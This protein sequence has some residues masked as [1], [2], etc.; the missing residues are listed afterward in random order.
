MS[1]M[2][3]DDPDTLYGY[4]PDKS[5]INQQMLKKIFEENPNLKEPKMASHTNDFN[6]VFNTVTDAIRKTMA[7]T[8]KEHITRVGIYGGSFNPIHVGHIETAMR[9]LDAHNGVDEIRFL[10]NPCSPFKRNNHMPD[11]YHRAKMIEMSIKSKEYE[12]YADRWD[13][14]ATEM[15]NSIYNHVCYTVNTLKEMLYNDIANGVTKEYFLIMGVDV[16]NNI[17]KF[18]NWQWFLDEKLVKFIVLPRGGYVMDESLKEEFSNVMHYVDFTG[19]DFEPITLSSTE[20]RELVQTGNDDELKKVLPKGAYSY[21][22]CKQLYQYPN[23]AVCDLPVQVEPTRLQK[24][25]V[26]KMPTSEECKAMLKKCPYAIVSDI[27]HG[28]AKVRTN[29]QGKYIYNLYN[30]LSGETITD[31]WFLNIDDMHAIDTV[32]PVKGNKFQYDYN[33]YNTG[34]FVPTESKYYSI[35]TS[36]EVVRNSYGATQYNARNILIFNS[37]SSYKIF[38]FDCYEPQGNYSNPQYIVSISESGIKGTLF[39]KTINGTEREVNLYKDCKQK[40]LIKK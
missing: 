22:K 30:F 14:D 32:T 16:F 39:I 21:I 9:L 17:K 19:F 18:K 35:I 1:R 11:A 40:Y 13:V 26:N 7:E 10:L 25:V 3:Y 15:V 5:D 29:S 28:L 37:Y 36:K 27:K 38:E 31:E 12:K 24:H 23:E 33:Q 4:D 2:F 20:I 8:A 6:A 34:M